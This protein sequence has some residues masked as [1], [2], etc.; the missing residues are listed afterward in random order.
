MEKTVLITGATGGIG[1]A[2]AAAFASDNTADGWR[3]AV[4]YNKN[5]DAAAALQK[6]LP[7]AGHYAVALAVDDAASVRAAFAEVEKQGGLSLLINCAGF[8]RFVA[9]SDLDGLDDE[10]IDSIFRVH[11]RGSLACIRAAAPLLQKQ[12]GAAVI[13]IT[14]VAAEIANGSNIAYCAAKAALNNVTKSLARA[15]A[16]DIRVNALAP[17]LVDTPFIKNLDEKW[18]AA[19]IAATPLRRLTAPE[20]V[21][22]AA[23]LLAKMP[24]ATGIVLPVDGGRPLA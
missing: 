23:V 14:S 9:H 1:A 2:M 12:K 18:R 3:V 19:Q 17:G 13:N 15:L 24:N 6:T 16:P 22:Q 11:V 20:E 10:L 5:H 8:T 4:A 7:G 21:A